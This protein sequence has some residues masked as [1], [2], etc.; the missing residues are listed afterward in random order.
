MDDKKYIEIKNRVGEVKRIPL[1]SLTI[2]V[3]VDEGDRL[4]HFAQ[5]SDIASELKKFGKSM[6]GSVV[7]RERRKGNAEVEGVVEKNEQSG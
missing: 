1:M 4:K 5:A 6:V 2:A 7:I 3:V